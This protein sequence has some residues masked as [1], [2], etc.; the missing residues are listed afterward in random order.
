MGGGWQELLRKALPTD[1][2]FPLIMRL[3]NDPGIRNVPDASLR[4]KTQVQLNN[5]TLK[6]G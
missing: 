3:A 1:H 2:D 5:F 6:R 4:L